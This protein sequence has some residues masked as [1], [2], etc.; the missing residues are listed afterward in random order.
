[1]KYVL[2]LC[3]ISAPGFWEQENLLAQ[4]ADGGL[5]QETFVGMFESQPMPDWVEEIPN[6]TPPPPVP[7]DG[8]LLALLA[9]GG[10]VGYRRYRDRKRG[11]QA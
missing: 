1:M 9:A 10:A 4:G 3:L 2:F 11:K 5:F 7:V 6:A 8:G